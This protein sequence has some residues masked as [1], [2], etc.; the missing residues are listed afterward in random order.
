MKWLKRPPEISLRFGSTPFL[1]SVRPTR[2]TW[3][4]RVNFFRI[5]S[6]GGWLS[7]IISGGE[8]DL[9][10]RNAI[11]IRSIGGKKERLPVLCRADADDF[12]TLLMGRRTLGAL[13]PTLLKNRGPLCAGSEKCEKQDFLGVILIACGFE[14]HATRAAS[15]IRRLPSREFCKKDALS[16]SRREFLPGRAGLVA[17]SVGR[18]LAFEWEARL[19]S[20][21]SNMLNR[22]KKS[23]KS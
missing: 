23:L 9:Q 12:L 15:L 3:A 8:F 4:P 11:F 7:T 19:A 13:R 22:M 21:T 17:P 2:I 18:H 5:P 20:S 10:A 6:S 1:C 16:H 14:R